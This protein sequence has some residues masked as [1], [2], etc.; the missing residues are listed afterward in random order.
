MCHTVDGERF[1][2]LN[3][4]SFS[5]I[6]VFAE[7]FSRCLGHKYSLFSIIKE[8]YLYSRIT[9]RGTP[10]NCEKCESLAQ[11]IF[12]DLRYSISNQQMQTKVTRLVRSD[13]LTKYITKILCLYKTLCSFVHKNIR[14]V[15]Q[16]YSYKNKSINNYEI[17]GVFL[18]ISNDKS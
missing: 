12:P 1:A 17:M 18:S 6:Q 4:H 8:R 5:A 14:F 13:N 11:R 16:T 10:E 7:I 2:G 3:I 9:F 15:T